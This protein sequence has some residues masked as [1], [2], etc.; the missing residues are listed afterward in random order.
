MATSWGGSRDRDLGVLP[1]SLLVWRSLPPYSS[2]ILVLDF[3]WEESFPPSLFL[4]FSYV[5][6][7]KKNKKTKPYIIFTNSIYVYKYNYILIKKIL[8]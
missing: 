8:K 5:L 4:K 1:L 7:Q 2:S 3:S 6:M